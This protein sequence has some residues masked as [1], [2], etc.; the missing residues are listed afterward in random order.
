MVIDFAVL[1]TMALRIA[2]Q[3]LRSS[4]V[5]FIVAAGIP[6]MCVLCDG[7]HDLS[8]GR[9]V[10]TYWVVDS[11]TLFGIHLV[12]SDL[13]WRG[14]GGPAWLHW[15]PIPLLARSLPASSSPTPLGYQVV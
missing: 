7:W 5:E 10:A 13:L 3:W 8:A 2:L 11:P 15:A 6:S 12:L 14:L 1:E 9:V 4:I